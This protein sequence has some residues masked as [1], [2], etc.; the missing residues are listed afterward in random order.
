[1]TSLYKHISTNRKDSTAPQCNGCPFMSWAA[2]CT[3]W[4]AAAL[5]FATQT[6]VFLCLANTRTSSAWQHIHLSAAWQPGQAPRVAGPWVRLWTSDKLHARYGKWIFFFL[7]WCAGAS[8][9]AHRGR[10]V[11]HEIKTNERDGSADGSDRR[12]L[13]ANKRGRVRFLP[14]QPRGP[15]SLPRLTATVHRGEDGHTSPVA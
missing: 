1:M 5:C 11:G 10:P 4:F 2:S 6:C 9:T 7:L 3:W 14:P 12:G 15:R 13:A 8:A